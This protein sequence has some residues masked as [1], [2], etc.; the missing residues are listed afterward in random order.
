MRDSVGARLRSFS[1]FA[2]VGNSNHPVKQLQCHGNHTDIPASAKWL[3]IGQAV[4][5]STGSQSVLSFQAGRPLLQA[6]SE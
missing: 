2:W 6:E 1:S 3:R 4:F 5:H